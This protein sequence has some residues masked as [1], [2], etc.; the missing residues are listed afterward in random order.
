MKKFISVAILFLL[1]PFGA[2]AEEGYFPSSRAT[3]D[4]TW[5]VMHESGYTGSYQEACRL[6]DI[7]SAQCAEAEQM[8]SEGQCQWVDI[9]N[10]VVLDGLTFTRDGKHR[11]DRNVRVGLE[12]PPTRKSEV[13]TTKDGWHVIRVSGCNNIA[14]VRPLKPLVIQVTKG[15][16]SRPTRK[17]FAGQSGCDLGREGRYI[18]VAMFTPPAAEHSCA[19][20]HMYAPDGRRNRGEDPTGWNPGGNSFS[21]NCGR[22]FWEGEKAGRLQLSK[23][24][25]PVEVVVEDGESE[26]IIFKGTLTGN[27]LVPSGDGVEVM[28]ANGKALMIPEVITSGVVVAR[29]GDY[30]KV[31]TPTA[32]GIGHPVEAFRQG[33]RVTRFTAIER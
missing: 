26:T 9:P 18:E 8:H 11:V 14:V 28:S 33:C 29:F 27:R 5:R 32:S 6:L 4:S 21:E 2:M 15:L 20:K 12:N 1:L 16:E 24:P 25:H 31:R 30:A 10:D 19:V 3:P 17:P 23:T 7:P 22:E 13:C